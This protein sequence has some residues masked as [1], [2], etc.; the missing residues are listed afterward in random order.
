MRTKWSAKHKELPQHYPDSVL[1]RKMLQMGWMNVEDFYT[2]SEIKKYL[3]RE[4]VRKLIL[5]E[6]KTI[7]E[8]VF[9]KI[10]ECLGFSANEIRE[11]GIKWGYDKTIHLIGEHKGTVLNPEE[12]ALLEIYKRLVTKRP[13]IKK[14]IFAFLD[15]LCTTLN[16]KY[17]DKINKIKA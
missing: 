16:V 15:S 17:S 3:S 7:G 6:D 13:D 9:I 2:Q 14:S 12:E 10:A 4:T 11:I 8:P 5:H 1:T